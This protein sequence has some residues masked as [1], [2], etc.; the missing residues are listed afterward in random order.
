MLV[1][2][3]QRWVSREFGTDILDV[4]ERGADP[5]GFGLD[6]SVGFG[7]HLADQGWYT[8]KEDPSFVARN[9]SFRVTKKRLVVEPNRGDDCERGIVKDIC[10][11]K[12]TP[13]ANFNYCPELIGYTR[14][15]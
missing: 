14:R 2:S 3:D 15:V 11:I 8:G 12:P 13:E 4:N 7:R 10:G 6:R 5:G 1:G 9:L